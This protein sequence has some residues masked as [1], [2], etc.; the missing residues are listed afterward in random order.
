[1]REAEFFSH[2]WQDLKPYSIL[3]LLVLDKNI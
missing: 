3:E 2:C 1:M